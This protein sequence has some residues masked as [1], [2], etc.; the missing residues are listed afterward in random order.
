MCL[1]NEIK[2]FISGGAKTFRDAAKGQYDGDSQAVKEIREEMMREINQS[3]D[4]NNIKNDRK[5][6]AVDIKRSFDKLII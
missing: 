5:N 4:G 3:E 2:R 6:V 1:I